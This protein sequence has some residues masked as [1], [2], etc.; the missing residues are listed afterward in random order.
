MCP[1]C[2]SSSPGLFP[3]KREPSYSGLLFWIPACAGMTRRVWPAEGEA[4]CF[5]R[6]KCY[7]IYYYYPSNILAEWRGVLV[8]PVQGDSRRIPLKVS[9]L[10]SRSL[11][12]SLHS[13]KVLRRMKG[14]VSFLRK[15]ESRLLCA[16]S[17]GSDGQSG[18]LG[19]F[20]DSRLRGNDT[21][22]LAR[23]ENG[24]L[25]HSAKMLPTP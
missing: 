9:D 16:C 13:A 11:Q 2:V 1:C 3:R 14:V 21:L 19:Y 20:L 4:S 7:K 23:P 22:G 17:C 24:R 5:I 18:P 6:L 12:G 10:T 15:Q 25:L 8:T